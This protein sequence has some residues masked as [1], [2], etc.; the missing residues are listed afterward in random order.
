MD[1]LFLKSNEKIMKNRNDPREKIKESGTASVSDAELLSLFFRNETDK[2]LSLLE[3]VGHNLNALAKLTISDMLLLGVNESAAVYLTAAVELGRR[4][5]H[6]EA[7][8]NGQIRGSKDAANYIRPLIGDLHHEEFWVIYLN[9]R[10]SIIFS[11]KLSQGGMTGTVIDVRLVLKSALEKYATSL[12]FAHNH[13]SG[14]LDP[15][16]ADKRITRQ[17]KQAAAIMEIPVIDHL[18]VTQS[19]YFSFADEGL[20]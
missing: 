15:S 17:L 18:I 2:A 10:N 16:E 4:R 19:S 6:S 20:L 14:N 11:N 13:P 9:R 3:S 1:G 12:I 8:E 5:N 7:I